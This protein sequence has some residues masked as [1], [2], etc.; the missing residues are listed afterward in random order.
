MLIMTLVVSALTVLSFLIGIYQLMNSNHRPAAAC[1]TLGGILTTA[2][3]VQYGTKLAMYYETPHGDRGGHSET[4][5]P[6]QHDTAGQPDPRKTAS[7]SKP[8]AT[9]QQNDQVRVE[10]KSEK[11]RSTF[12]SRT[13]TPTPPPQPQPQ[14]N[15]IA[16]SL[17]LEALTVEID[18]ISGSGDVIDNSLNEIKRQQAAAGYNLR[19]DVAERQKSLEMNRFRIYESVR[20]HDA[21][22]ARKFMDLAWQDIEY[23]HHFLGR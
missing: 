22:R 14:P 6:P 9:P 7:D 11:S 5:E 13:A 10:G 19:T 15:L 21:A 23:L 4:T 20:Q 17:E 12:I 8:D 2:I 16:A 3:L 1:F 18:Q